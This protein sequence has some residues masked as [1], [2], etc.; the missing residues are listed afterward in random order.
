MDEVSARIATDCIEDLRLSVSPSQFGYKV[1]A[2][3]AHV[4]VRLEFQVE[5]VNRSGHPDIVATSGMDRMNFEVEAQF[6]RPR[7]RQLTKDDFSAL[8][9]V[10]G[11]LGYFALAI[12]FPTP[13]WVVVPADRLKRRNACSNVLLEALSDSEFSEAWTSAYIELLKQKCGRIRRASFGTLC[14]RA[15]SGRGP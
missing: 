9:D 15:L 3:A 2:L 1:Q 4:L 11:G 14:E 6:G 10:P 5:Q 8:T 7:R 13:R 12:G